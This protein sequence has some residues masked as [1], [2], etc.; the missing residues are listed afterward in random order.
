ME[1]Q[2]GNNVGQRRKFTKVTISA[3]AKHTALFCTIIQSDTCYK[4][5]CFP[6]ILPLFHPS[7]AH[8]HTH[9]HFLPSLLHQ[10]LVCHGVKAAN[11][12]RVRVRGQLDSEHFNVPLLTPSVRFLHPIPPPH[13]SLHPPTCLHP[14]AP[15][16]TL[17]SVHRSLNTVCFSDEWPGCEV[18]TTE[19]AR[20]KASTCKKKRMRRHDGRPTAPTGPS[21]QTN[22]RL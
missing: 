19:V 15:K 20:T 10:S 11:P 22:R 21:V 1:H 14:Q 2:S 17:G 9:T 3:G 6:F 16:R 8:V 12:S 18:A 5:H 7:V 4:T 13:T